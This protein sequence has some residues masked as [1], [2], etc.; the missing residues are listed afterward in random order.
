MD[1]PWVLF[2]FQ[3]PQLFCKFFSGKAH[4]P[5]ST[6]VNRFIFVHYRCIHM[7]GVRTI[8]F[9]LASFLV[10][11]SALLS[12]AAE[13]PTVSFVNDILPILSRAGCNAGKCHAKPEGQNGFKLSVFAY[14]PASDYEQ[15]VK[16]NYG[17]RI[18]TAVEA[19]SK[20]NLPCTKSWSIGS[21]RALPIPFLANRA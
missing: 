8:I 7:P 13:L 17:R 16:A 11:V 19:G 3:C 4:H 20:K 6:V 18:F 9:R 14:D 15:I 21:A 5:F 1:R 10:M 2:E 12:P